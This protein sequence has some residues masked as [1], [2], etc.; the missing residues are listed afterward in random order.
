M[1]YHILTG[2]F[3]LEDHRDLERDMEREAELDKHW[4]FFW[5]SGVDFEGFF[6]RQQLANAKTPEEFQIIGRT[7]A[8]IY[9]DDVSDYVEG[10]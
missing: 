3:D 2:H 8:K 4:I 1:S 10:A 5:K 9:R 6:F 7:L